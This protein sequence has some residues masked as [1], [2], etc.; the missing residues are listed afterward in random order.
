MNNGKN[1]RASIRRT[2]REALGRRPEGT[3]VEAA[4]LYHHFVQH[5][6]TRDIGPVPNEL[7]DQARVVA[8]HVIPEHGIRALN[9]A[10]V[11]DHVFEVEKIV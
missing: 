4:F 7:R 2:L 8:E 9:K 3:E 1:A 5:S 11:P 10:H 6:M